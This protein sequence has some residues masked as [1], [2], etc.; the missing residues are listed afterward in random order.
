MF[1]GLSLKLKNFLGNLLVKGQKNM[2]DA[3][4]PLIELLERDFEN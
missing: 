2:A 3:K 1:C 4:Y